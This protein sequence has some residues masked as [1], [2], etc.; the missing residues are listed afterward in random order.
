MPQ[1]REHL[2]ILTLM[3]LRH[4]LV[5]LT[6]VDLVEADH[7]Q[8]VAQELRRLLANPFL[9]DA[10]ICPMSNLTGEGY[11][12]FYDS[13]NA[14]VTA[15][16]SRPC[17]GWSRVWVED[18]FTI[19]GAGTVVTGIPTHG[20][21]RPGD[22]LTLLPTGQTTPVRRLQVYGEDATEG[23]AGECVALNV[24]ELDH[25]AVRRGMGL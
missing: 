21:V 14:V 15:C 3:G 13:L 8:C 2:Q 17:R 7:H 22:A 11:G 10:P 24:P 5:A 1:T 20:L 23:R 4:G 18:V 6:K 12:D 16:E 19:R 9:A 25:G